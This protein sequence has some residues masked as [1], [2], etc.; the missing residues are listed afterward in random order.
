[1]KLHNLKQIIRGWLPQEP[2]NLNKIRHYSAPI[3]IGLV[4]TLVSLS[5]FAF[6]SNFILGSSAV[7]PLSPITSVNGTANQNITEA[8]PPQNSTIT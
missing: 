7:R 4:V 8:A 5:V 2:S 1:M 3:A 6:S